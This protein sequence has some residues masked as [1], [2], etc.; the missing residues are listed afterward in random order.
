DSTVT[1][2]EVSSLFEEL[3]EIGSL[4]VVVY[5]YDGLPMHPP[6]PDYVPGLEELEQAPPL[7]VYVPYVPELVYPKFMPPEDEVFP[8]KDQPLPVAVSPTTDSPGYIADSDPE[9]DPEEDPADYPVDG[10]DDDDDD[11]ESSDDD[12]DDDDDIEED[13]D[14]DKDEEEEHP[15]PADSVSPP[16]YCTTARISIPAQAPVLFLSEADVYRLL[17]IRTLPP[18]PLTPLSSPLPQIPPPPLPVSS[19]LPVSPLPLPASPT[20]PLGYQAAMIWLRAESPSTSYP[21]PLP[22]SGT[23]HILPIPLLTSS[24]PLLLASTDRRAGIPEVCLPHQKRLCIALSPRYEI[25]ESLS[26]PT[27]RLTGGFRADY[28]FDEMVED[29]Q[30]TPAATDVAGPSQRMTDF[31]MTIRQDTDEIY[32]RLDDTHDDRSLMSGRLNMLYR[33][34]RAHARTARL[35]ETEARLSR[36]AWVQSMDASDTARSEV[37]ALR[38]TML[39]QQAKIGALRVANRTRQAHLVETLTLMSTLQTQVT[40]LQ[41]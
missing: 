24:P 30:G 40:A 13:E 11:D 15:A 35:M 5:G 20:H 22:P 28:G 26:A 34:R 2:T 16:A 37:N 38:T 41:R 21:L 23:P 9:E 19:P 32:V 7:H 39:A 8:A 10:G 14:K 27:A 29:M 12:E 17:V 36:K 6:S 33:D 25:E 31:V 18:S 4:G 3:S 1:Y